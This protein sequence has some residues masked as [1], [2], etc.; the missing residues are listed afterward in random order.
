MTLFS[1]MR[2]VY[3][4]YQQG[5][6]V[7]G[8]VPATAAFPAAG[9]LFRV[10]HPARA[11]AF[12]GYFWGFGVLEIDP[13]ALGLGTILIRRARGLLLDGTPFDLAAD[14]ARPLAFDFPP[15]VKDATVCLVSPPLREGVESVIY[16]EDGAS[17]ARF[18]AATFEV[19][20]ANAPGSGAAEIQIARPRFRLMLE[21]DLRFSSPA[22]SASRNGC[23][24]GCNSQRRIAPSSG[25]GA[26]PGNWGAALRYPTGRTASASMPAR[27]GWPITWRSCRA[28]SACGNCAIGCAITWATNSRGMSG[29]SCGMMNF[30]RCGSV[31]PRVGWGA[32]W[33]GQPPGSE[34][35]GCLILEGERPEAPR[36]H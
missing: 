5:G 19:E 17:A 36:M 25:S 9:A 22:R 18:G 29:S 6:L 32:I 20:D 11:G 14:E 13:D 27:C 1:R 28:A 2:G 3:R 24:T 26:P 7:E 35:P 34:D 33:L 23:R 8:H 15:H 30:L 12:E 16:D 21:A 4:L 31:R 10:F